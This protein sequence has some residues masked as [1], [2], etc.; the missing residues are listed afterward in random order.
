M[1][2]GGTASPDAMMPNHSLLSTKGSSG[3]HSRSM[4][5]ALAGST[6]CQSSAISGASRWTSRYITSLSLL[7][8]SLPPRCHLA[9]ASSP[10]LHLPSTPLHLSASPLSAQGEVFA[11]NGRY[12][13]AKAMLDTFTE[14]RVS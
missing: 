9:T 13:Y 3:G 14:F 6:A 4:P 10:P 11:F 8:T 7:T 1:I 12:R 2:A 5:W